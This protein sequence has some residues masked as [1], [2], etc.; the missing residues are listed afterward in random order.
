MVRFAIGYD[1][2]MTSFVVLVTKGN[3]SGPIHQRLFYLPDEINREKTMT[4][5]TSTTILKR[6]SRL[7]LQPGYLRIW[8]MVHG[9]TF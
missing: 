1:R 6:I 8:L 3:K 5:F 9:Y 2:N 7:T 4:F